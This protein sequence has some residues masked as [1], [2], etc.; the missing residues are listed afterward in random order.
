M[1]LL[2]DAMQSC[3][4]IDRNTNT[5]DGYGGYKT[6]Y[7][8][9]APFKAAIYLSQSIQTKVAE[10]QGVKGLYQVTTGRDVRLEFH[11]LFKRLADPENGIEELVLRVTSKDENATPKSTTLDM[12]VVSAEE[13][14][15]TDG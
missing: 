13:W 9:G 15:L 8:E 11:D 12:R 6:T 1:S 14:S 7:T 10:Q 2:S 4:F 3:V 5:P